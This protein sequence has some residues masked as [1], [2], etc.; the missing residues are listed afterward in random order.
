MKKFSIITPTYNRANFLPLIYESLIKQDFLDIEWIIIDDGSND[1]TKEI[2][3]NFERKFDIIYFYQKNAGKPTAMNLGLSLANSLISVSF[4]SD[5]IFTDNALKT[6]W[7]YYDSPSG[8]FKYNCVCVSGLCQYDN[9]DIIG[10]KFPKDVYISNHI[11][12]RHNINIKGDKLDFILTDVFK[13]TLFPVFPNEKNI[14]PGIVLTLFSFNENTIYINDVL[15][16]KQFLPGGLSTQNYWFKY[17]LGSS[18]YYN[19]SSVPPF[20]TILRIKHSGLYIY[21]S[22]LGKCNNIFRKANNKNVFLLGYFYYIYFTIKLFLKNIIILQYI[23]DKLK[24]Y[25]NIFFNKSINSK[26]F[27]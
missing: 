22:K 16:E 19:V 13:K 9:G 5:D 27:K 23:N 2:V 24:L 25:Y 15:C 6:I 21:F 26:V 8:K 20:K 3:D 12:C 17:P 10:D 11:Q 14:A 18:Y 1:N 7:N 4:D